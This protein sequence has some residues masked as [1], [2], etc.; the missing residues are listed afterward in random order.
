M[1]NVFYQNKNLFNKYT[2]NR[3][4]LIFWKET[5]DFDQQ[6]N[7]LKKFKNF[8]FADYLI[9]SNRF[10][11][12]DLENLKKLILFAKNHNKK[13]IILSKSTEFRSFQSSYTLYDKYVIKNFN[14]KN[15]KINLKDFK[16]NLEKIYF[17]NKIS[18]DDL[19]KQIYNI[20]IKE[21]VKFLN[22]EELLCNN[23]NNT[24][25][26]ITP[27]GEKIFYDYGHY[28]IAGAKYIGELIYNKN[29]LKLD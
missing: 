12:N 26:A 7:R 6:L 15:H 19:N 18:F 17:K 24:C 21:N 11:K 20:T 8:Y 25:L 3:E 13:M 10:Q 14:K 23:I 2:F 5:A 9:V 27:N 22:K 16:N 1:F 4:E 29:W 28:T